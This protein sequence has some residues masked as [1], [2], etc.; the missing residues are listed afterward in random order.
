MPRKIMF[1][2][3]DGEGHMRTVVAFSSRGAVK[4]YLRKFP[5]AIDEELG[6]KERGV[7]GWENFTV[8]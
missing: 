8:H 5:T 7:D 6:V 1:L 2:V 4:S 3:R